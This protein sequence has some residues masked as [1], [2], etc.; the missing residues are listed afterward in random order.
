MKAEKMFNRSKHMIA[1]WI[2][3][4]VIC[5][6]ALHLFSQEEAKPLQFDVKLVSLFVSVTDKTGANIGGLSKDDFQLCEDGKLQNI[7]V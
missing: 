2:C 4:A 7:K 5:G 6:L 1:L 3:T